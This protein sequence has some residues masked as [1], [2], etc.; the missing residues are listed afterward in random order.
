MNKNY[1]KKVKYFI[2]KNWKLIETI[3]AEEKQYLFKIKI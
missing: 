1:P 3:E 2:N